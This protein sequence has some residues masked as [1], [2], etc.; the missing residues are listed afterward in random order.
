MV[1]F[2]DDFV[3]EAGWLAAAA[4]RFEDE[5]DIVGLTGDVVADGIK[6]PGLRFTEVDR[7]LAALAPV[8][9]AAPV[10][11]FSPYGCNMAVPSLGHRHAALRRAARPV[12]L[13][14]GPR[15]RRGPGGP[16]RP[17]RQMHGGPAASIWA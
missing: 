3:P 4:Q 9:P 8:E 5:P 1:F 11:A 6:G 12:R 17:A 15:F 13:A 10:E 14:R 7:M 16:R 2:D